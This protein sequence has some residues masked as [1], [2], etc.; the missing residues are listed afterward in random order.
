MPVARPPE[1]ALKACPASTARPWGGAGRGGGSARLGARVVARA[2][3]ALGLLGHVEAHLDQR[4]LALAARRVV[5][6]ELQQHL[7]PA[8]VLPLAPA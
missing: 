5:H 6:R 2:G 4:I 7:A 1:R 3:K 8:R